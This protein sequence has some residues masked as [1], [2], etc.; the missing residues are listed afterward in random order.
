MPLV[1][2][3]SRMAPRDRSH[4]C[5]ARSLLLNVI[6]DQVAVNKMEAEMHTR[7]RRTKPQRDAANGKRKSTDIEQQA[8]RMAMSNDVEMC[9]AVMNQSPRAHHQSPQAQA[10]CGR[11]DSV[12]HFSACVCFDD[13]QLRAV[14]SDDFVAHG[15]GNVGAQTLQGP[16][17]SVNSCER[18]RV[19][20]V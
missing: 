19:L 12:I 9:D 20:R 5:V 15:E 18:D 14:R 2:Q 1:R 17:V 10:T 13:Q 3:A 6:L 11:A 8:P 4:E 16:N 7:R